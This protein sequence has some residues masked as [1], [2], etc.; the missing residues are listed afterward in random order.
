MGEAR[1]C[2][3]CSITAGHRR[4]KRIWV[5]GFHRVHSLPSCLAFGA[6]ACKRC[7]MLALARPDTDAPER[8]KMSR[9]HLRVTPA[10]ALC[11]TP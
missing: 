10:R 5:S 3:V 9:Q 7:T 8:I 6:V 1:T 2:L 4:S 11:P